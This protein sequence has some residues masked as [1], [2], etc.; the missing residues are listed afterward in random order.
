M[1]NEGATEVRYTQE[2]LGVAINR[3]ALIQAIA[4]APPATIIH[5]KNYE[6]KNGH[7]EVANFFYN[8]GVNYQTM[9]EKSLDELSFMEHDESFGI[10]VVWNMWVDADGNRSNRKAKG[11]WMQKLTETYAF[12]HPLLTEAFAKVRQSLTAPRPASVEYDKLG[13]G[14]YEYDGV[15]HIRDCSLIRKDVV[16]SGDYPESAQEAVNALADAIRR[17][18][19]IGKYRQVRLDG[20]FDYIAL[21]GQIVMQSENG[22]EAYI[23]LSEHKNSLQ[24]RIPNLVE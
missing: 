17:K 19:S 4:D 20:R 21:Q 8:K 1:S 18:L 5:V 22:S 16:K 2:Q 10:V 24:P 13:N 11:R 6:A 15:L 7:G 14:V 3:N 23:G 12:G 9:K